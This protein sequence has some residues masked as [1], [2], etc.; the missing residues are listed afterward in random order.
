MLT[1]LLYGWMLSTSHGAVKTANAPSFNSMLD[2]VS[3]SPISFFE[4]VFQDHM[5]HLRPSNTKTANNESF[6]ISD[7]L[8]PW[9]NWTTIN[10]FHSLRGLALHN[11]SGAKLAN[12]AW[13]ANLDE[14]IEYLEHK[15]HSIV[16]YQERLSPEMDLYGL[17]PI[18]S[19]IEALLGVPVTLHYYLSGPNAQALQP[20]T[21]TTE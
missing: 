16:T 21:D 8:A 18:A 14:F 4:D 11:S 15:G 9:R 20:H 6:V 1:L 2:Q 13:P 17:L 3:L 19:D 7:P 12:E 5:V 10:R